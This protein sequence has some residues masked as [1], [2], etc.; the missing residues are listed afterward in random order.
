M[1]TNWVVYDVKDT[2]FESNSQQQSD[3]DPERIRCL[4]CQRYNF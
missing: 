4:R 3:L 2:I 1:K